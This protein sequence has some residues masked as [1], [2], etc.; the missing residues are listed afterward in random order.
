M[1]VAPLGIVGF[2][3]WLANKRISGQLEDAD[4][5]DLGEREPVT[6]QP[7]VSSSTIS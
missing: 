5:L 6:S 3:L 4:N 7:D 1:V 2:L